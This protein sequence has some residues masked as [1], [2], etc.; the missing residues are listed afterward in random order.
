MQAPRTPG[1]ELSLA[2]KRLGGAELQNGG[3]PGKIAAADDS[4]QAAE[5]NLADWLR[6]GTDQDRQRGFGV[7]TVTERDLLT[8]SSFALT[9]GEKASG[10]L[11]ADRTRGAVTAGLLV[12][13]SLG[14]GTYRGGAGGPANGAVSSNLTGFYPGGPYAVSEQL[15]VWGVAGYGAGTLTLTPEKQA[16]IR[17]DLDLMM[18]AAG[19]PGVLA[20]PETGGFELAAK[21]D[22]MGVRTST[23]KARGSDGEKLG[24]AEA[25]VTRLR[26]GLEGSRPFNFEDGATLTP[27]VEI[28]VRHDGGDAETGFG[29]DIGGGIAWSDPKRGLSAELRGRSSA[30]RR[31]TSLSAGLGA[32]L[33][34][35]FSVYLRGPDFE[36]A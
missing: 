20:A 29:V 11:G 10:M 1:V 25:A 12:S 17:T 33:A 13:Y 22:A 6:N 28:G 18:A 24:A 19:L 23:A 31:A 35:R 21:T 27:S 2:G 4:A 8:G 14:E 16:P 30:R 9:D 15:S 36:A 26:L 5:R 3:A 34:W 32:W 7:R